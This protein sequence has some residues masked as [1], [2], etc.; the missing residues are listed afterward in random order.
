MANSEA[1]LKKSK[2][3]DA[4]Q[5]HLNRMR[6]GQFTFEQAGFRFVSP[7]RGA[8][9]LRMF[10]EEFAKAP[11]AERPALLKAQAA[12]IAGP[13]L[14]HTL[15]LAKP[16]LIPTFRPLPGLYTQRIRSGDLEGA[17]MVGE[18]ANALAQM[19]EDV[20]LGIGY[21]DGIATVQL[22]ALDLE[23]L[24]VS[25]SDALHIA[26]QNLRLVSGKPFKEVHYGVHQST[27]QDANDAA[28]LCLPELVL[29]LPVKGD[30]IAMI[31]T[32]DH[33]FIAGS[34]DEPALWHMLDLAAKLL[35]TEPL[36]LS[37]ELLHLRDGQ[38]APW[39]PRAS[40]L[41]DRTRELRLKFIADEYVTQAEAIAEVVGS[42]G[43]PLHVEPILVGKS[44]IDGWKSYCGIPPARPAWMPQAD[45]VA[46]QVPHSTEVII[47][48]WDA[49][50]EQTA[51]LLE[52][53]AIL[54][55]RYKVLRDLTEEDVRRLRAVAVERRP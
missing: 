2:Y 3:V 17:A 28:R 20:A 12:L 25:F 43:R 6:P 49:F 19:N 27:F 44:E 30:P 52:A 38:W 40:R 7:V 51:D 15:E 18:L 46:V 9:G 29:E 13:D 4:I 33:L 21:Q 26:K 50:C 14:P 39:S 47:A 37:P 36:V 11:P 54:P 5:A 42:T 34:N 24:D 23:K 32:R 41:A 45:F 48:T 10:F 8:F 16:H 53:I 1:R 31:P 55:R 22:L 35:A